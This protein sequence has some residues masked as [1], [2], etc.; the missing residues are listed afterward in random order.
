MVTEANGRPSLS[1][2]GER[3][4]QGL[5]D[6]KWELEEGEGAVEKEVVDLKE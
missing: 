3:A 6:M 2:E 5:Q 1:E 4:L